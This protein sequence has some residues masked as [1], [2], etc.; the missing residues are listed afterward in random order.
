MADSKTSS[1]SNSRG[2]GMALTIHERSFKKKPA[3]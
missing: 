3:E 2:L 1:G